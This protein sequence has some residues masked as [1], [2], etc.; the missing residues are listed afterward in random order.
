VA[1][2]ILFKRSETK[3]WREELEC[4]KLLSTNENLACKT[5]LN[6]TNVKEIKRILHCKLDAKKNKTRKMQP[7]L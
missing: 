7:L 4:S 2:H 1:R 6:C 3:K 5:M